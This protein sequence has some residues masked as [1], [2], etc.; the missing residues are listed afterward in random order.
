MCEPVSRDAAATM[1]IE[2]WVR[3]SL[4]EAIRVLA[5]WSGSVVISTATGLTVWALVD[6]PPM[7]EV[8]L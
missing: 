4:A 3:G 6:K 2:T 5:I 7:Q 8:D 1:L